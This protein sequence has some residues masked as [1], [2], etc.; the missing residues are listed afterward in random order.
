MKKLLLL[1]SLLFSSFT[2][3]DDFRP[4]S[5]TIQA[6]TNNQFSVTWKVPIKNRQLPQLKVIFDSLTKEKLPKRSRVIDG[7]Y[8]QS[9]Q[10]SRENNLSG[11]TITIDGLEGS[12]YEVILRIPT[13]DPRTNTITKILNT[14]DFTFTVA[15]N[16]ELSS[17][18]IFIS[19]LSLGFEHILAG[20]DHLLFVLALILLVASR[21]KLFWTIT[22]FTLA[23]SLTLA[24]V[25]L[26]WLYFPGPPVEAVIALSI[27]FLAKEIIV[28]HRGKPSLTA[29]YPWLVAFIFGLLH[30][31]GFASALSEIGVPENEI[32]IAL[33]SFNIGVELGQLTFVFVVLSMIFFS[34]KLFTQLPHWSKQVPAYVI[35]CTACFWFIQRLLLF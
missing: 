15:T 6:L 14:D 18:D 3:S 10:I 11:L 27:I 20:I 21:K 33:F 12:S 25:T 9:W 19:Y 4:A 29:Q 8:I 23:H 5:L 35:G 34:K 13:R 30:G 22:F 26:D 1:I 17:S 16:Q 32:F 7:S 24:A 2:F 28:V 31:M